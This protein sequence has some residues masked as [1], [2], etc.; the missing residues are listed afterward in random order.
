MPSPKAAHSIINRE[1]Y[2]HL[3]GGRNPLGCLSFDLENKNWETDIITPLPEKR[4]H[5]SI[6]ET[7][8]KLY[9]VGGRQSSVVKADCWEYD[10]ETKEWKVIAVLPKPRDGQSACLYNNQIHIIGGED[11]HEGIT[12]DRHDILALSSLE[13]SEGEP[14]K[15]A[16][17]EFISELLDNKWYIYGG[18]KKASVKTLYSTT[19]DLEIM[20]LKT[21]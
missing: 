4:D 6:L 13:W 14:L 17:H 10:F 21:Q 9:V 19:S 7:E 3:I 15:L 5:I 11:L 1:P 2:L 8:D 18:G 16:R 20:N 12:Y